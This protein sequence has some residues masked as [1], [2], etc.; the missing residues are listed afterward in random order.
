MK[1]AL[2]LALALIMLLSLCACGGSSAPASSA[3]PAA[4]ADNSSASAESSAPAGDG[5][6][7]NLRFASTETEGNLR[8]TMLEKPIMD[9]ITEKTN[10]RITFTFYAS[11]TL[12]GSGAI[13]KGMQDGIC[14]IGGDNINSYPG[15]FRYAELMQTPGI[16]L[17]GSYDEKYENIGAY[18]D[19]YIIDE[20]KNNGIYPLFTAPAL[21][22]VLMST[23]PV[24]TTDSYKGKTICANAN[25]A[26]M[27]EDYGAAITWVVPPEQYESFRLNV[28][29]GSVNGL[30]PISAFKLYEVLNYAYYIP[31]AT[32]TSSYYMSLDTY[33]SLPADLQ[34]ILDEIVMGDELLAINRAYVEAM[35]ESTMSD[36]TAGNP[37]FTFCDL[38][39]DVSAAMQGSCQSTIDSV[40]SGLNS[41]GLDGDAA[42]ELL[43]SFS[44]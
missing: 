10:G 20:A 13:I 17:G 21:D 16:S 18:Y 29:D 9:L 40:V 14:D 24:E 38:P 25:Y 8:Y 30:G 39:A 19:A 6:V 26:K 36:C 23:F 41:A 28:I 42:L 3:A 34:A 27:F 33:N 2:S 12:A 4:P 22:V 5:K 15:V 11:S 35:T 37:D 7:Y 43:E 32:V 44:K 31:F 1:K